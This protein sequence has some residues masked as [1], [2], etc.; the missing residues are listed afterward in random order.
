MVMKNYD[1]NTA[2]KKQTGCAAE[3]GIRT[4]EA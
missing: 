2:I 3:V 1:K 4:H